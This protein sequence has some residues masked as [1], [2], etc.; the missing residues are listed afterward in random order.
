MTRTDKIRKLSVAIKDYRGIYNSNSGKWIRG[1]ME[2]ALPRVRARLE[3]LDMDVPA[4]IVKID[5]FETV[6]DMSLFLMELAEAKPS[7]HS[8][9]NARIVNSDLITTLTGNKVVI[10]NIPDGAHEPSCD[11]SACCPN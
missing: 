3:R 1:P 4:A 9:K 8:P 11:C 10:E 5:G 6:D 7:T 2:S